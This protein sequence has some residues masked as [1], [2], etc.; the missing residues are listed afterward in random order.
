[1][2]LSNTAR[3]GFTGPN[4]AS[5]MLYF[6]GTGQTTELGGSVVTY[7]A[8]EP[9]PDLEKL[10]SNEPAAYANRPPDQLNAKKPRRAPA[11]KKDA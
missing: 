7:K 2:K 11:K 10:A 6:E 5:G 1:M 3:F 8:G 4:E 9:K